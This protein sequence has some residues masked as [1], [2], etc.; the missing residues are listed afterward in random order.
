[1]APA[2]ALNVVPKVKPESCVPVAVKIA[3]AP[4]LIVEPTSEPEAPR[5]VTPP[6]RFS[7]LIV[8]TPLRFTVPPPTLKLVA[9]TA[10]LKVRMAL[11]EVAMVPA[12]TVLP[13]TV[14][15]ALL[16]LIVP[17]PALTAPLRLMR[18][19]SP[20]PSPARVRPVEVTLPLMVI[21]R[22]LACM[23]LVMVSRSAPALREL[24]DRLAL[25][26]RLTR[27]L[28]DVFVPSRLSSVI[29]FVNS[30]PALVALRFSV[31][32]L[33][34]VKPCL[35]ASALMSSVQPPASPMV[36]VRSPLTLSKFSSAVS[37]PAPGPTPS[38]G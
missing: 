14:V 32:L 16:M 5:L 7:V 3:P 35:A 28:F 25:V 27:L 23:L 18:P 10:P 4:R 20:L 34:L 37:V 11:A 21:C 29:A 6:V 19:M 30:V 24:I 2:A 15:A 33:L 1:M 13:K 8:L 26:V 31:R 36:T 22:P 9:V 38:P 17:P 12:L